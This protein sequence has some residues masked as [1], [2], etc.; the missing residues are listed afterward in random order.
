MLVVRTAKEPDPVNIVPVRA[1][2]PVY[3]I[4][5]QRSSLAAA[6]TVCVRERAAP[7]VAFVD[8]SLDRIRNMARAAD[9]L[10]RCLP[11]LAAHCES[12]LLD[13]LDQQIECPFQDGREVSVRYAVPEQVLRLPQLVPK[14]AAGGELDLERLLR[15]GC[16]ERA[17]RGCS[18]RRR[19]RNW[20]RFSR[21]QSC[22][23]TRRRSR[24]P[25]KLADQRGNGRLRRKPCDQLLDAS[26][27]FASCLRQDFAMVLL[28]QVWHEH[29]QSGQV[30]LS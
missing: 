3:V 4:E 29:A 30:Y 26:L 24:K 23:R 18:P 2:E 6:A 12:L 9:F 20:W 11:G 17:P 10:L 16:E 1:R 13:V 25:W 5:F 7:A 8:R 27:R 15:Q 21:R 14:C 19:R 22:R 28:N